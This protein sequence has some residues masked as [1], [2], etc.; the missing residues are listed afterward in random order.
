VTFDSR[1]GG[2]KFSLAV[3]NLMDEFYYYNKFGGS[4]FALNG[5]PGRPREWAVSVRRDF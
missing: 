4:G 3:K 1:N 5:Q 2:W